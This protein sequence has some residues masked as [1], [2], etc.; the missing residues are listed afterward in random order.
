[1]TIKPKTVRKL[2]RV[3]LATLILLCAAIFISIIYESREDV[4]NLDPYSKCLNTPIKLKDVATIRWYDTNLRF[5]NYSLVLNEA[6]DYD[7]DEVKSVKVYQPGETITFFEAKSYTSL[8]V[9]TTYYLIGRDTL[10]T[11]ETIEFEYYY[12]GGIPP[13]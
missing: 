2:L 4:S 6:S 5:S 12:S 3:V 1:M 7:T 8:H 10:D 13:F 11:G 9:G